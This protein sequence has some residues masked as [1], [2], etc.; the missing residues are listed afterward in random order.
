MR[1]IA[2][3]SIFSNNQ[4]TESWRLNPPLR[5]ASR[6]VILVSRLK[7]VAK[8]CEEENP[9]SMAT[10]VTVAPLPIRRR[11]ASAIRR[12]RA[13]SAGG[14]PHISLKSALKRE[15]ERPATDERTSMVSLS[16]LS[17]WDRMWWMTSAKRRAPI[18]ADDLA[19][20][21]KTSSK[22]ATILLQRAVFF[23]KPCPA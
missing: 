20:A 15:G 5:A 13:Y 12:R 17:R 4:T 22:N 11:R 6:G 10:W 7:E 2:T 9:R 16:G 14:M 18:S 3:R 21:S 19:R 1:S 8:Y 23:I